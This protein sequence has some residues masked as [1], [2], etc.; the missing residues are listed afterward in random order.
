MPGAGQRC[1]VIFIGCLLLFSQTAS[2]SDSKREADF[3]DEIAK[4]HALG[5][6]LWLEAKGKK[7]LGLYTETEKRINKGTIIILHDMGG[8][9]NQLRLIKSLRTFLPQHHW[10]TLSLQMPLW[11]MDATEAEYYVLFPEAAARIKAGVDYLKAHNNETLILVGY[12]LGAM[13]AV[14][15]LSQQTPDITAVALVSLAAPGNPNPQAQMLEFIQKIT[16]P[17]LDIYA[18]RDQAAVVAAARDKRVAAKKNPAYQQIKISDED[19][20]F[21]HDE[22]LVVKRIYSWIERTVANQNDKDQRPV[23]INGPMPQQP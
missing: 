7:F 18:E 5:K 13:M 9:P 17:M 3:A 16:I 10:S 14:Y 23:N 11:E 19:H 12:G 1:I 20:L 2:A 21:Q 15:A 22:G 4:T 8:H 6:L